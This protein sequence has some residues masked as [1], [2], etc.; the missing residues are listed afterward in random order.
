MATS[1][2]PSHPLTQEELSHIRDECREKCVAFAALEKANTLTASDHTQWLK[3]IKEWNSINEELKQLRAAELLAQQ[4]QKEWVEVEQ[5]SDWT[6][7]E[8]E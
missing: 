7:V 6:F 1:V 2:H 4:D 5:E 3:C 8:R